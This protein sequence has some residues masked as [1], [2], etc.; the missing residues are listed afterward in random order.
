VE[1]INL[2]MIYLIHCEN[3][4]KCH[5]ISPPSTIIKGKKLSKVEPQLNNWNKSH[6]VVVSNIFYGLLGVIC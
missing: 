2:I 3:F 1:G 5:D 6:L 4:C